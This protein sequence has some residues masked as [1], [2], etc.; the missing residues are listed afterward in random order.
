MDERLL[1]R[2]IEESY[3]TINSLILVLKAYEYELSEIDQNILLNAEMFLVVF[4][5]DAE[6]LEFLEEEGV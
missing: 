1:K 6:L 5:S 3:A 2:V 4:D